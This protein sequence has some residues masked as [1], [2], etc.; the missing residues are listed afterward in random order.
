MCEFDTSSHEAVVSQWL[1]LCMSTQMVMGSNPI[2]ASHYTLKCIKTHTPP[3]SQLKHFISGYKAVI[4]YTPTG[5]CNTSH[6]CY[7]TSVDS[8]PVIRRKDSRVRSASSA[9]TAAGNSLELCIRQTELVSS[10]GSLGVCTWQCP[11]H[12]L[13]L[14]L[15][16]QATWALLHSR[17]PSLSSLF[18]PPPP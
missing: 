12:W 13:L 4:I 10:V 8:S 3:R 17:G 16:T 15:M 5:T 6:T 1:R 2:T 9:P 14:Y 11:S 18:P 7:L